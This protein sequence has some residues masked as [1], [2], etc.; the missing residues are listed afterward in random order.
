MGAQAALLGG[1]GAGGGGALRAD[2]PAGIRESALSMSSGGW[3]RELPGVGSGEGGMALGLGAGT[4][5]SRSDGVEVGALS[6][7]LPP[8]LVRCTLT[9]PAPPFPSSNT[10]SFCPTRPPSPFSVYV[11]VSLS[12][13]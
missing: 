7:P 5:Y 3:S 1:G 4:R 2:L 10:A 8:H 9:P 13:T 12:V 11:R 6:P